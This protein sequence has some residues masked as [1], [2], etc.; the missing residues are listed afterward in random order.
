MRNRKTDWRRGHKIYRNLG[1]AVALWI[2]QDLHS[3]SVRAVFEPLEMFIGRRFL[4]V[5]VAV[6]AGKY[7][8]A[9][10]HIKLYWSD[11]QIQSI[12]KVSAVYE[13]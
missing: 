11:W 3:K 2:S 7:M 8:Q 9:A 6:G 4:L 1:V 5:G 12:S 13:L 10:C